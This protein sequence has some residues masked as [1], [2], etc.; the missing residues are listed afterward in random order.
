M[1][2]LSN[3]K[4]RWR[5]HAS[6]VAR[7]FTFIELVAV[8]VIAGALV[9]IALPVHD[10]LRWD[11]RKA[12]QDGIRAT[13]RANIVAARAAYVVRGL[14]PGNTVQINGLAIEV[15]PE[16]GIA[17]GYPVLPGSPTPLGMY[18]MLGCGDDSPAVGTTVPCASIA[19]H[20]VERWT[21][22]LFVW[23]AKTGIVGTASRCRA[24]Y[25]AAWGAV[26]AYVFPDWDQDN[27]GTYGDYYKSTDPDPVNAAGAC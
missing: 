26:P 6:C 15:Y 13:M 3:R 12:A 10:S 11:A 16:G 5:T 17:S 27:I 21:N 14:E 7:G 8:L 20:L 1:Q 18:R 2:S 4:G 22:M 25:S 24:V 9:A 19:G 23:P